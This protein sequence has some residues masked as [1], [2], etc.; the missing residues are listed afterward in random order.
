MNKIMRLALA[1]V[2]RHKKEAV[3]LGFLIMLCM[4]LLSGALSA[5][6]S[7]R[8]MYPDLEARTGA[9][10]N[11]L[12]IVEQDYSAETLKFLQ[13]DE[14]VESCAEYHYISSAST[15]IF[16]KNGKEQLYIVTFMTEENE[17]IFEHYEPQTTLSASEIAAMQHPIIVPVSQKKR[18]GLHEGDEFSFINDSK[19]FTFT[20]AGFYESG[21]F[22]EPKCIVNNA[23][24][25]VMRNVFDRYA[26]IGF[27]VKDEAETK[28]ILDDFFQQCADEGIYTEHLNESSAEQMRT[29]FNTEI[30]YILRIMEIMAVIILIAV[31]AMIGYSIIT[32]IREQIVSIGVLEALGYRSREIALSYASEYVLIALAGCLAG[33]LTGI[34]LQ[35]ILIYNA[36]NMKGCQADRTVPLLT[37]TCVFAGLLLTVFLLAFVKARAVKKYPPVLAFRKGIQNHHFGKS[38][39]PLRNTKG[40]VHLRLSLKGFADNAKKSVGLTFVMSITTFAVVLSFILYSFLGRGMNVVNAVAG[41]ELADIQIAAVTGTDNDAFIAELESMP[42][43]RKVLPTCQMSEYC[44]DLLDCNDGAYADIYRDYSETENIFP[45]EGRFPQHDNEIMAAKQCAAQLGLQCGQSITLHYDVSAEFIITGFVT[46]VVNPQAIYLTEDGMK[47]ICPQFQPDSFQIYAA[48]GI[49]SE[50]LRAELDR[51]FG[52]SAEN[53]GSAENAVAGSYEERIRAKAEQVIASMIEQDGTA[54]VE[55][56][57]R[58]GDT[59]ISGNSSGIKIRSFLNIP[60]LLSYALEMLCTA[61]SV[62]TALFMGISAIVVMMILAI[63]TESEIRRQRRELGVMKSMGYT[64]KELMMQLAFRIMPAALTAVVIGTVLAVSGTK[65]LVSFIGNVPVSLPAVLLLDCVILAFCFGCAYV[66]AGK[67]RKISVYEL[68]TE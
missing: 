7:I 50:T 26:E 42:E 4:A 58:S 49:S 11:R 9:W 57:I 55:Y 27:R 19:R 1:N 44:I 6:K 61:V 47:R 51:R 23:D 41:H 56:A 59:V 20:V 62:T 34:G 36:E 68:M 30:M 32:D 16:D 48:E 8:R 17:R 37:Y 18:L 45:C 40:N 63:L 67:I 15:R 65:L 60:E 38:H 35:Q 12:C 43:I 46:A 25:A 64:S 29:T 3:L 24:Y 5:E 52:K 39:F 33:T 31:A 13:A 22:T 10:Q 21:Y 53:L 66:S 2:R 54:N 28:A 14:R